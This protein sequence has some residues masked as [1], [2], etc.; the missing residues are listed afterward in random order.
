MPHVW[1]RDRPARLHAVALQAARGRDHRLSRLAGRA[2]RGVV[3][4]QVVTLGQ[5]LVL[6]G[7]TSIRKRV[8]GRTTTLHSERVAQCSSRGDTSRG[9]MWPLLVSGRGKHHCCR[10]ADHDT[11]CTVMAT[12]LPL[13]SYLY[14]PG[15]RWTARIRR[16]LN[17]SEG[18]VGY[19]LDAHFVRKTFWTVSAWID[20]SSLG[21]FSRS[22]PHRAA[23]EAIRPRMGQTTFLT[24]R[25]SDATCRWAGKR[26]GG[27]STKPATHP[28]DRRRASQ[29]TARHAQHA[30]T[31]ELA[32]VA[33]CLW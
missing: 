23:T 15:F 8:H 19:A 4:R 12:L 11:E 14:I 1:P 33:G 6:T 25:W 20:E 28:R 7:D 17:E 21:R 29:A 24:G 31:P 32:Q 16:Q 30:R 9:H 2:G 18:L 27:G 5:Q 26:C 22:D 10:D 13:Q 3:G